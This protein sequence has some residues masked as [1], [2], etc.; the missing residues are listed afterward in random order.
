MS[1]IPYIED[2][3]QT[4]GMANYNATKVLMPKGTRLEKYMNDQK[5]DP[6]TY[7]RMIYLINTKLYITFYVSVVNHFL[8]D[9]QLPLVI[10]VKQI[11][12]YLKG[13]I[14]CGTFYKRGGNIELEVFL[15]VDWVGDIQQ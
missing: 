2:I 1:Q 13:T 3:F 8:V 14:D 5:I 10:V 6:T 9:L 7:M 4:F 11:F 12:K 15:D